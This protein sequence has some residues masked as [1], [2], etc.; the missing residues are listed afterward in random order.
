MDLFICVKVLLYFGLTA[1][2]L[3]SLRPHNHLMHLLSCIEFL[4]LFQ[5]IFF[6]EQFGV[7][8]RNLQ[9]SSGAS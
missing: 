9:I 4:K 8:W 3:S 2:D 1:L 7:S 6:R 5:R